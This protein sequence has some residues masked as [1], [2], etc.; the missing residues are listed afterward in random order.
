[1]SLA[2]GTRLGSYEVVEPIGAGGMGEVY[3]A[4]DARLH[5]DVAI[6]VLPESFAADADRLIR[7][8]R[9]A[10]TLAS[11]NHPNIAQVY[12]VEE[13][14]SRRALIMEFVD[15]ED[16]SQRLS[17]GAMPLEDVLPA[18]KQIAEALEAAHEQ[19]IVHRDLKPANIKL[20]A[21]G[22]IKVLDFGL[23]KAFDPA[24]A[25]SP[26]LANSPTLT[27]RATQ[28]GIVIGTAAYMAPEQAKGRAVDKRAD[29]W[30]FGVVLYEMLSGQRGYEAED[31]SD[32]L[33][34]VLTREVDWSKLPAA[35]P[36]RLTAL[37]HDCLMRDAKQRLRDMGEARR[38]LDQII[39]GTSGSMP[40]A[41]A[42]LVAVGATAKWRIALPWI[43]TA[44][45]VLVAAA[46]VWRSQPAGAPP[47][48]VTRAR[49]T[50]PEVAGLLDISRD[51]SKVVYTRADAATG[52]KLDLRQMDQFTGQSIPGAEGGVTP[53]FSP[54]ADW[55]AF[56]TTD[57]KI[58]KTPITGGAAMTLAAGSFANGAAW[59]DD[60]TIVFAGAHGLLRMPRGGGTPATLTTTDASKGEIAHVY[61]QF[62]SGGRLLFTI[63]YVSS[64][65]QFAV[66]DLQ[67]GTYRTIARS[68]DHGHYA[69]SG[70]LLSA[71]DGTL[72]AQPFDLSRMITTGPEVP[73]VESVSAVGPAA[74]T[75]DYAVSDN[76]VLVYA[77]GVGGGSTVL[78]W[79]DRKGTNIPLP[80]QMP[81]SWGTGRL[82]PDGRRVANSITTDTGSDIW[83]VD[84]SRGTPARLTFNGHAG[85]PIWTPD[86]RTIYYASNADGK[87]GIYKVAADGSGKATLVF[88]TA[89]PTPDS[90][91]PDGRTL[92][93]DQPAPSGR[94]QIMILPLQ[95]DGS[96]TGARAMRESAGSDTSAQISPDGQSI[97]FVS[98]ESGPPEVYVM[99]FPGP[100]A[101]VQVSERGANRER[102][103]ANGRELFFWDALGG[104]AT[105]Y[106]AAITPSPL[107]AAPPV[108]LF[109][110][111]AGTT[112]GVAPDGQHF[113]VES[114][115]Q[116]ATF[117]T[118][119]NWFDELRRRAPPKQ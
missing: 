106:S 26:E 89:N 1:M 58:K 93:F 32:T 6:K 92:L 46:M 103:A 72:F 25:S 116:G 98:T 64:D 52:F 74:G 34:A 16:L 49:T 100:G 47:L 73:V 3:R 83:V 40:A 75:A 104:S 107:S 62:L 111:F 99:P 85:F 95:Q 9:E 27:M 23:A 41:T 31:V 94:H 45:A 96:A 119:T 10:R 35:T 51:G 39:T 114:V 59:G 48:P 37:L 55:I 20:R 97:A 15:G 71:R 68:G 84:L 112:W 42:P 28:L 76:G 81:R 8:E 54:A 19:G 113:L 101:K 117:V 82:S 90:F 88:A 17:R 21:D 12:G 86:G 91:T 44:A 57:N 66:L 2:R 5:R 4:H 80:G 29:I 67:R 56:S 79:R 87:D 33:A 69:A 7:F 118:V 78:T 77:E 22:T 36:P 110:T 50:M 65:P 11:L 13:Q 115:A 30:A 43:V 109:S 102:W 61:P 63:R 14:G 108:P 18:A 38:V 105:L 70:H 53:I 24:G 60:D